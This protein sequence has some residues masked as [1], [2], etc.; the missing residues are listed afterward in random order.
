MRDSP[1]VGLTQS[2]HLFPPLHEHI[3]SP[4]AHEAVVAPNSP[5]I[6]KAEGAPS[7]EGSMPDS[8][9]RSMSDTSAL[10]TARGPV[11]RGCARPGDASGDT[12]ALMRRTASANFRSWITTCARRHLFWLPTPH[13]G[14]GNINHKITA[15][16]T[17]C[18][19]AM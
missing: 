2:W 1:A 6:T 7:T 13:Q 19:L 16:A 3:G 10:S 17:G 4:P 11:M 18:C 9:V 5:P 14:P 8:S 15:S 12:A